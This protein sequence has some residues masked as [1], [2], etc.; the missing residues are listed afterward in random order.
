MRIFRILVIALPI[1]Y[2]IYFCY[3]K[4][5]DQ[6][7]W[8]QESI[9]IKGIIDDYPE[10]RISSNRYRIKISELNGIKVT[11]KS[12]ILIITNPYTEYSYGNK[13]E[14]TGAIENPKDFITDT[15]KTFDYD[16]YLKLSKIYGIAKDPRIKILEEFNGNRIKKFLF[17]IRE[18]FSNNLNK[19]LNTNT[20]TLAR[21]V[22]LG[23]RT[24]IDNN[25]RDNLART[26][27]SHIIALS[28]YNI[29]I[30]S[31]ILMKVLNNFSIVIKSTIGILGIFLFIALAGG[32][33]SAVRA[34]IMAT[35]LIYARSR[36]FT[37]NALWALVIATNIL[38][39]INPLAL[40]HD[41]GFHL[42]V[43]ATF[44]LICFQAPINVWLIKHKI[45]KFVSETI[46]TT[47]AASIMSFPYIAYNMGIIS[48][49][50][51]FVNTV[52]VPLIPPLMLFSFLTGITTGNFEFLAKIFG[53]ITEKISEI[54][55]LT[56][57]K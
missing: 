53:F 48:I 22:L 45:N 54:I 25:L 56:I 34:G 16:N 47:L 57:N 7:L 42:S 5:E 41:M 31:E 8:P 2:G 43:L 4:K 30:V 33:S 1:I 39:I 26:S 52:V 9:T 29:T 50:G 24:S 28:G 11:D 20:S 13:V 6:I 55:L 46:S 49:L 35:V 37:Y 14:I 12:K 23:E 27:T 36:G 32:G 17:K 44:G 51:I 19:N 15:G 38:I 21:G 10:K 40:R 3:F 18:N